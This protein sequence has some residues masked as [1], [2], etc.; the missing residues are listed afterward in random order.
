MMGLPRGL[1]RLLFGFILVLG[2]EDLFFFFWSSRPMVTWAVAD[3]E[4]L[5][6]MSLEGGGMKDS[7]FFSLLPLR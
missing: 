2:I 6:V 7:G 3:G 4:S 5:L 1:T